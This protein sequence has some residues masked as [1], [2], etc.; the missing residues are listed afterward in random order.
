MWWNS[1]Y[2]LTQ[3]TIII[4]VFTTYESAR[5]FLLQNFWQIVDRKVDNFVLCIMD[6]CIMRIWM[7]LNCPVRSKCLLNRPKGQRYQGK[8]KLIKMFY[9]NV[10][11]YRLKVRAPKLI[12][13]G[14]GPD[15]LPP[16]ILQHILIRLKKFSYA[17]YQDFNSMV[18]LL[19]ITIV[20]K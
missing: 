20:N 6:L 5:P 8:I 16:N 19:F 1:Q 15:F 3:I 12:L 11:L 18:F 9:F 13:Q 10:S 4:N 7:H 17:K 14:G 2:S